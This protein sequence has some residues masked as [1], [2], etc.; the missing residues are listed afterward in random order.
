MSLTMYQA[1][2]APYIH[3]LKVLAALLAKGEAYARETGADPASYVQA[4][5]APDMM[6][7]AGQVQR[8]SDTSKLAVQRLSGV[9]SPPMEDKETTFAE[10]QGRVD[11]TIAYLRGVTPTQMEGSDAKTINLKF[12]PLE[13]S[14]AGDDYVFEFALPNFYFHLTAAYAILRHVGVPLGK[15]DYLALS[16]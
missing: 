4:R 1:S 6:T 10:L 11:R 15:R 2:V 9:A 8:A 5:L 12:G 3:G 14:F 7:L 13:A 16:L